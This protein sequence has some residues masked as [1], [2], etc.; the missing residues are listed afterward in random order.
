MTKKPLQNVFSVFAVFVIA[1]ALTLQAFFVPNV[2]AAQITSRKLTLQAGASDGGSEF[3][4][5]GDPA[6]VNHFFEFTV[7]TTGTAIGSIRFEYCMTAADVGASTCVT[8]SGLVTTSA[9]LGSEGTNAA[10]FSMVNTTNG[11][12]YLTRAAST[13][14]GG[15]LSYRLDSVTNPDF[16]GTFFVRISTYA[17]TTAT[18]TATDK[19]SVNASTAES[20]ILSG[21]MPESLIFCTGAD[22]SKVASVVDCSTATPGTIE[23]NQLFS[24]TETA[25]AISKMAASTNAG[26]GYVITVNGPTLTSG[27]NT[28]APIIAGSGLASSQGVAQF[29]LNLVA[30][31]GAAALGFETDTLITPLELQTPSANIDSVSDGVNLNGR[32]FT[33]YASPDTF[34]FDTASGQN[35]VADSNFNAAGN[36]EP[37][38]AQIYTVS[39]IA[40]VP[41]SQP[42]GTY[43]S[44][45]TYICTP[46][47]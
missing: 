2:S 25:S 23:F 44:T 4:T 10:G 16:E 27:S 28:I 31:T 18:G 12:P 11:S 40:N 29:G 45:L 20:I 46:T 37:S 26:F 9:T 19:G 15:A 35:V 22:I 43:T 3:S 13:P 41:G 1:L 21:T 5:G 39:Y 38:D 42:A 32:P 34:K 14:S 33:G 30:N 24:P 7:P 6:V 17:N 47:F 36:P 8:P